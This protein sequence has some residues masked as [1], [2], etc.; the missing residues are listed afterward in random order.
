MK[1]KLICMLLV[2]CLAFVFSA[3]S[4]QSSDQDYQDDGST[5]GV[6]GYD[7][8]EGV[9]NDELELLA[10]EPNDENRD[11]FFLLRDGKNYSL[12]TID[13]EKGASVLPYLVGSGDRYGSYVGYSLYGDSQVSPVGAFDWGFFS[14]GN[15]PVPV[16]KQGDKIVSYSTKGVPSLQLRKVDFY[17]YAIRLKSTSDKY[18]V[19]DTAI[20]P[21]SFPI[22][23]TSIKNS[24]GEVVE[25]IFNLNEGDI[26]TISYYE[27]TQYKEI[28]LPADSKCYAQESGR[29]DDPEYEIEGTL[30]ENGYAE[31][32]IN[33][34]EPGFYRIINGDDW[35]VQGLLEIQ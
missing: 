17:G 29:L 19:F 10:R 15:V 22:D 24:S 13:K 2:I 31:Y 8:S 9:D 3:C 33:E 4:Q 18:I 6:E 20:G 25:D 34:V 32:D 16:Y 26:Y 27:G 1:K 5:D 23:G 12:G 14:Y 11:N 30:T 7:K 21:V 35:I 28:T